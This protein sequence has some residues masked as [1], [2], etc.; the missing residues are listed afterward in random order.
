MSQMS[1]ELLQQSHLN[2]QNLQY[3]RSPPLNQQHDFFIP[4]CENS[5]NLPSLTPQVEVQIYPK[6]G[7]DLENSSQKNQHPNSFQ[8]VNSDSII[9]L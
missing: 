4:S 7:P 3:S 8:S 9:D 1:Q 6:I 2:Q 5:S